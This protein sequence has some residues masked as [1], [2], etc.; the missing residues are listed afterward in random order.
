MA[1]GL[2]W[3][4]SRRAVAVVLTGAVA[5]NVM[6]LLVRGAGFVL[7]DWFVLRN[8]RFGGAWHAAGTLQGAARPGSYPIFALVFGG[9]GLHPLPGFLLLAALNSA[10]AVLTFHVLDRLVP[11]WQAALV[12]L[13]WVVLPTHTA[14]EMWLTCTIIAASQLLLTAALVLVVR[15]DRR[16]SHEVGVWLLVAA[17][18]L[19]YEASL[20]VAVFAAIGLG[21][22]TAR[23][24]DIV[25][26]LGCLAAAG[27]PG[28]WILLHWYSGKH[29]HEAADP[30]R[31][32]QVNFGWGITPDGPF[33]PIADL[34]L[35]GVVVGLTVVVA[36]VLLSR[37]SAGIED[38]LVLGG[39]VVM[40]LGF[41]P[42]VRYFY[43][44]QGAGDR[45]NYLS[46][47]GGAMVWAGLV[48][49][50]GRIDRRLAIGAVV[51]LIGLAV[52]AR[53]ERI[54]VWS[55]AG[56]DAQAIVDGV[57]AAHPDPSA[58][59]VLGPEPILHWNVSAMIDSSNVHGAFAV[60][61]GTEDIDVRLVFDESDW[62]TV[63]R[64]QQFDI[65][66]VS[67]LDDLSVMDG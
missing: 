27:L 15:P 3:Q 48:G 2:T 36:R 23:R 39:V 16:R 25:F 22:I 54:V 43:E 49:L 60:A 26:T 18:I 20:P 28:L 59:V 52:P 30:L 5:A 14:S 55:T 46:A 9:F 8:A 29:L 4:P 32:L 50:L 31:L 57:L 61:Y 47:V 42:F 17:S 56:Q 6:I 53:L 1:E 51:A 44:P 40:A 66:P 12:A 7:D 37:F 63:D 19:C 64:A 21:W 24:V 65:R 38:W 62:V 11:R 67:E 45:V 10:T 35:L 13:L 33:S 34:L 58:P 41:A